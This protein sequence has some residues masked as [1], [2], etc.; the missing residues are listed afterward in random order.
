MPSSFTSPVPG[1]AIWSAGGSGE[2]RATG[3]AVLS[4]LR[5]GLLWDQDASADAVAAAVDDSAR[6][7][8]SATTLNALAALLARYGHTTFAQAVRSDASR[9]GAT[10]SRPTMQA[11]LWAAYS[12]ATLR[13]TATGA[14]TP[15]HPGS[16]ASYTFDANT[17]LPTIGSLAPTPLD[18][19]TSG[20]SCSVS[21][22]S[23]D[24]TPVTQTGVA[25]I[26]PLLLAVLIVS[27]GAAG[28]VL[29]TAARKQ[30]GE[31]W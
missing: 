31:N 24:T 25:A 20:I 2:C 17:Q 5:A 21:S 30:H 12:T 13:N 27:V 15:N 29:M 7:G 26:N 16:P 1:S 18:G 4:D 8:W 14:R 10:M 6:T 11:V 19:V 22:Q 9:P 23:T 28:L 3:R